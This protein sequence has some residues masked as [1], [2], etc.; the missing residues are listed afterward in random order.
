[1]GT[2]SRSSQVFNTMALICNNDWEIFELIQKKK[3]I[4]RI[5]HYKEDIKSNLKVSFS[6]TYYTFQN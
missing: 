3:W 2:L 1:M 5:N 6:R 4:P